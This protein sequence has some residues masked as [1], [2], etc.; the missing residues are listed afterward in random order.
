MRV[1]QASFIFVYNNNGLPYLTYI[2][3]HHFAF[4]ALL[5]N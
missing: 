5:I 3:P 1:E 2:Y 4:T